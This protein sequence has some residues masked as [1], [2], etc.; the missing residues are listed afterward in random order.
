[1]PAHGRRRAA[2]VDED[3]QGHV[4]VRVT[5][6]SDGG[7]S[8]QEHDRPSGLPV[9]WQG[10]VA[11]AVAVAAFALCLAG[12]LGGGGAVAL[13]W[14]PTLGLR[15]AFT[16]DGH[17][18]LYA[19][20]ATG[21]GALVFAYGTGYLTSHLEHEH[22]PAAERWRFWPWMTLF[23]VAMV[24]LATAQ[25]LVLLFV[26]FDLTAVCSY[27]LIGFDRTKREA[28]TAAMMALLVTVVSAIALLLAAVL[29]H[30][31]Y[32]TFAIPELAVRAQ[33]GTTTTVA[34][35]LLAVGALAKSAQ[36][37]L[38][39]WLPRAMAAPTPVSAYLHSVAMVAA[40]V[41][42]LG[43]VHPL[44]AR[45]EAVLDGL[46]VV[47]TASIVVGGVLALGQDKLKQVL[48]YSTISQYG[49]VVFLYGIGGAA[50]AGAAGFY[51]LAHGVGKSALFMTAGAV[52]LATGEDRLSRL[53][54]LGRRAPLL[55]VASGA[56]AANLAALPLTVGFFKDE[57]FFAAALGAGPVQAGLAV[58]AAA[59][60]F[61]YIGRFWTLLFLGPTRTEPGAEPGALSGLLAAP[62]VVLAAVT[63]LGG[64]M[65]APFA[66][67]AAAA[68]SV[69][70]AAPVTLSPAYHLDARSENLM[71]LTAWAL[72][73]LLL[74][75]RGSVARVSRGVAAV[76]DRVGPRRIYTA[77]L[78]GL[79]R[80]SAAVH[81][82][83]VRDVRT[84]VA[85]VLVPA[86]ALIALAFATTPT[87]GAYSV[88]AVA[89]RDWLMLALLTLVVVAGAAVARAGA[90]LGM[91]LALSVVGFALAGVYALAAAPDVALVAV[92]VETMLTLVFLAALA[93]LP[94][95]GPGG[96]RPRP[97]GGG[98]VAPVGRSE[99]R[100]RDLLAGGVAGLATFAGVWGFLSQPAHETSI[101]AEHIR[102]T[103]TAHGKDVVT[104]IVADFRGLDTLVEISVLVV[105]GVGVATLLRRGRLW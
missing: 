73:G 66:D 97:S 7:T 64:V 74:A 99:N 61:A 24:G 95:Q 30:A 77:V 23:A 44:L 65:V 29:L 80:V 11:C 20:L 63:V 26:F 16:L 36:V 54:G 85:A 8:S 37:P 33:P 9:D 89:G 25:D 46:L 6:G 94:R 4:T 55:A 53:G 18:A 19:L 35:A 96:I 93:R 21:V 2:A 14:A 82:R 69:T 5:A 58:L 38:H 57:L 31:A 105:A 28:R 17:G 92:V 42:V 102:L 60:T 75:L 39:F 50:G 32:G 41:L 10:W 90:R 67:L 81:A 86:G 13:P 88:G 79:S 3:W 87:R 15:L 27:F 103:P 84:S 34:G 40:G 49:Y 83:E 101:A 70:N 71:A 76:G 91:V 48:A 72:G 47:G 51:V 98:V 62:V 68:G 78:G 1:M 22:R 45:S 104:V 56:A 43:R 100:R 12:W 59:L 52:T